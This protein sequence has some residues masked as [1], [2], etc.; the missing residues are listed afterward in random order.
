MLQLKG[1]VLLRRDLL[2]RKEDRVTWVN[3][4]LSI[5]IVTIRMNLLFALSNMC[6][7]KIHDPGLNHIT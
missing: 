6:G 3:Q 7:V 2:S 5:N 4:I 1:S